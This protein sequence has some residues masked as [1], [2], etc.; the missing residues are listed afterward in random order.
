MRTSGA[1]NDRFLTF[2]P[3]L[4]AVLILFALIGGPST[5]LRTF[6]RFL[7]DLVEMAVSAASSL[8]ARL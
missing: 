6:D 4:A 8:R 7:R 1:G 2:I 3:I 5:V